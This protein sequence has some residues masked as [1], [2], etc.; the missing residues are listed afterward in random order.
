MSDT[1]PN[2]A[3]ETNADEA[4]EATVEETTE[5]DP[6]LDAIRA[7]EEATAAAFAEQGRLPHAFTPTTAAEAMR[8]AYGDDVGTNVGDNA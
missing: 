2:E 6:R 8:E 3:P 1:T 5:A 4:P 7:Q